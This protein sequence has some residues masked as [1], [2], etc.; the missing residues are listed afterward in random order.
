MKFS[1]KHTDYIPQEDEIYVSHLLESEQNYVYA[2]MGESHKIAINS[3][4]LNKKIKSS[5]FLLAKTIT[6]KIV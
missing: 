1:I 2:N 3:D 5:G 6:G 4:S